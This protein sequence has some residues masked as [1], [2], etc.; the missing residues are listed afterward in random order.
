M[1]A[2][3]C[4]LLLTLGCNSNP[5]PG[6][7]DGATSVP[8]LSSPA[9]LPP[10]LAAPASCTRTSDCGPGQWCSGITH[11]CPGGDSF[12]E[13]TGVCRRDCSLGACTCVDD[14]DCGRGGFCDHGSCGPHGGSCVNAPCTRAGCSVQRPDDLV[15]P[16]CVCPSC[17]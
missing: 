17:S 11:P 10:G 2:L 15:C 4:G 1:R 3:L 13:G 12:V 9:D 6:A 7:A 16:V 14:L 8:D 5:L